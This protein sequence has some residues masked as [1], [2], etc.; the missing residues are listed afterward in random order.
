M[1]ATTVSSAPRRP[2]GV[3]LEPP[4]ALPKV[5]DRAPARGVVSLRLPT[6][7]TA[8]ED[9]VRAYLAA[10]VRE[11]IDGLERLLMTSDWVPLGGM[12]RSSLKAQWQ[13]RVK[14]YDYKQLAGVEIARLDLIERY[15]WSELA[16]AGALPRPS[17]MRQ[18]D[19]I[20]RVPITV[21][22]VGADQLFP[23]VL[24]LLVR[25]E[26]GGRVRIAGVSEEGGN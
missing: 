4:S 9:L 19:V 7:A 13:Q 21:A 24:V 15:E 17:E 25:R 12:P 20:V 14:N 8:I 11:D 2:D 10:F 3:H 6:G 16:A 18:G 26:E 22:R 23:D 5:G 1:T